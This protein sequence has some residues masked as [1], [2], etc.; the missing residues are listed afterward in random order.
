VIS[1]KRL[2]LGSAAGLLLAS[3]IASGCG[4]RATE[5]HAT[6]GQADSV[7][8]ESPK[9]SA[10]AE[11]LLDETPIQSCKDLLEKSWSP[12]RDAEPDITW[13]PTSGEALIS[14]S[15]GETVDELHINVFTDP[16]CTAVPF[17]GGL[18]KNMVSDLETRRRA[19]CKSTIDLLQSGDLKYPEGD[20]TVDPEK[21][22]MYAE[23]ICPD[24]MQPAIP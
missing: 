22:R 20:Q 15:S 5:G 21:L 6:D 9:A 7:A 19:E 3:P 16:S 4:N 13:D 18:V 2:L 8:S 23:S 12:P 24:D 1:T 17:L 11:P 10:L 14:F